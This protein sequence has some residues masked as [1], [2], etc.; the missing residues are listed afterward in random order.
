M[1][2]FADSIDASALGLAILLLFDERG[3]EGHLLT[4]LFIPFDK[5]DGLTTMLATARRLVAAMD[6]LPVTD[7]E[8]LSTKDQELVTRTQHGIGR[9]VSMLSAF[10]SPRSLLE[11]KETH[12]IENREAALPSN[13]RFSPVGTFVRIRRDIFPVAQHIWAAR[14]LETLRL[15]VLRM[16]VSTFLDIMDAEDEEL[17]PLR[18]TTSS[19]LPPLSELPDFVRP[20]PMTLM[21]P[22]ADPARVDQ[23]VDMGF[24]RTAAE[25]ALQRAR[26]NIA[27]ATDL[28]LTQPHLFPNEPEPEA[29]PAP[30]PTAEPA[31]AEPA[32][33]GAAAE[34]DAEPATT[35][36]APSTSAEETAPESVAEGS[37][38]DASTTAEPAASTTDEAAPTSA[39]TP[40]MDVDPAPSPTAIYEGQLAEL[41]K[42]REPYKEQVPQR[43]MELL[44][45]V[46]DLVSDLLPAFRSGIAGC[47]FFLRHIREANDAQ[48][49]D[50]KAIASR[51]RIFSVFTRTSDM[52]V[53]NEE[54]AEKSIAVLM[55]LEPTFEPRPKWLS[56]Y[57][58][59]IESLLLMTSTVVETTVDD[60]DPQTYDPTVPM[61]HDVFSAEPARVDKVVS[62]ALETLR[63]KDLT[64]E[65]TMSA[66]RILVVL[67]RN[68]PARCTPDL[69]RVVLS[70]FKP[71]GSNL[72]GCHQLVAMIVR[73][74]F[75]DKAVLRD[76]MR[77]EI[78]TWLQI[79]RNKNPADVIYYLRQL[80]Q[81]VYRDATT[82][83]N[84][85]QEE[86]ELL[87][88]KPTT[89]VYHLR[90][91]DSGL[92]EEGKEGKEG[93]GK[94]AED[95]KDAAASAPS[96]ADPFKSG[97]IDT[98][99][100]SPVMDFFLAEL[101]AT[102][103]TIH[104]EENAYR[105]GTAFTQEA[106]DAYAYAGLIL[107]LVTELVGSYLVAKKAFLAALRHGS[108][109]GKGKGMSGLLSDLLCCV[110]L[111][112]VQNKTGSTEARRITLS[113]WASSLVIAL[114]A[115]VTPTTDAKEIS[116]EL[117][118]V[119]KA[120]LD[121]V[122]KM[123]KDSSSASPDPS[124]R[125]G[126]LW[127]L[128]ELIFRLLTASPT[129]VPLPHDDSSLYIAKTMLEKN[130][131]S[132][133]TAAV[134]EI[135]LNYPDIR[136]VLV[137]LLRALE[138]LTKTSI[139]W[140]KAEKHK[141]DAEQDVD[142]DDGSSISELLSDI[143]MSEEE[144]DAPELYRN[145]ALGILGGDV[146]LDEDEDDMDEDDLEDEEELVRC[147]G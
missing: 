12:I 42:L 3:A 50:D 41:N 15:P 131:V 104:K 68:S 29:A 109:Y 78:R 88:P 30:A 5:K 137:S 118:I 124:A 36:G 24:G 102:V 52:V 14:W 122:A 133:M 110:T 100:T 141:D 27:A 126:R 111:N 117:V 71:C 25:R 95:D 9:V 74:A 94:A 28:L 136:N 84:A 79:N 6:R 58:L 62:A 1:P 72:T 116:E 8:Q 113:G 70:L 120:V 121:G 69:L 22:P 26:N 81:L 82:F 98:F 140:G 119:R 101:G 40:E 64:R 76:V 31:A 127:V 48:P 91:K 20:P 130:F 57:F 73:H 114:C 46:E 18:T 135:D 142:D 35:E 11:S 47:E 16:A 129:V 45:K 145:S 44:D 86:C 96:S 43:A 59:A 49:R 108:L 4:T 103:R 39:E 93:K 2:D 83:V 21:R 144:G 66:L 105:L 75:D 56:A 106:A 13:K 32:A 134:S 77:R 54:Q 53:L 51:L 92:E 90:R 85:T 55:A 138:H 132:L 107:S 23:L 10:A 33:D 61:V 63:G 87:N 123:L 147:C 125:Y 37:T 143:A 17:K 97:V 7:T 146:D 65:E 115:N 19:G 38:A 112:D 80:R 34:T 99:E 60:A 128:G 139:K 89:G 67:T